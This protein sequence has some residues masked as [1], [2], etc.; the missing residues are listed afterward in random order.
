MIHARLQQLPSLSNQKPQNVLF[1]LSKS[2]R[3]NVNVFTLD[4]ALALPFA[5]A[6]MSTMVAPEEDMS[7]TVVPATGRLAATRAVYGPTGVLFSMWTK[8]QKRIYNT[9][10]LRSLVMLNT[11]QEPERTGVFLTASCAKRRA[12]RGQSSPIAS[13]Q[14]Q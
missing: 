12:A 11:K 14:K 4:T 1:V 9:R 5:A 2:K 7:I 10:L 13:P 8:G 3:S 6:D